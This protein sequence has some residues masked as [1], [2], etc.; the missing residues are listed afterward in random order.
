MERGMDVQ[1]RIAQQAKRH[2]AVEE[3]LKL[4][5]LRRTNPGH[6]PEAGGACFVSMAW[7]FSIGTDRRRDDHVTET[8]TECSGTWLCLR[9]RLCLR[10][11]MVGSGTD[12]IR[13][14]GYTVRVEQ[15]LRSRLH[16]KTI[17]RGKPTARNEQTFRRHFALI[18][19]RNQDMARKLRQSRYRANPPKEADLIVLVIFRDLQ[20][21]WREY[22][23]G[24]RDKRSLREF[25]QVAYEIMIDY[26]LNGTCKSELYR[27]FRKMCPANYP[28]VL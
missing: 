13:A 1:G 21:V 4:V 7:K 10:D 23:Q 20:T 22:E 17:L 19:G 16:T 25:E 6:P 14:T 26:L 2:W 15:S 3:D 24:T 18:N 28:Y 8:T 11:L 9:G 5:R 27:R 12:I